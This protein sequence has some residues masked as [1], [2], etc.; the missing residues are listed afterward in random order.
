[1]REKMKEVIKYLERLRSNI[2]AI[3]KLRREHK[4]LTDI[5]EKEGL[6][7]S[8]RIKNCRVL[9]NRVSEVIVDE[10]FLKALLQAKKKQEVKEIKVVLDA[11][12]S[13]KHNH[14]CITGEQYLKQNKLYEFEL[15][16][17]SYEP[18]FGF[19]FDLYEPVFGFAF[20]LLY[21]PSWEFQ[22]AE[23]LR[24]KTSDNI[25]EMYD[26][27][28]GTHTLMINQIAQGRAKF[29]AFSMPVTAFEGSEGALMKLV[30]KTTG[31]TAKSAIQ[32]TKAS[33]VGK[34]NNKYVNIWK[35][36]MIHWNIVE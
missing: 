16:F 17:N 9:N 36:S 34:L 30:F 6:L 35:G 7:T 18:G 10:Q 28:T 19:A 22:N 14:L 26:D 23:L 15:H 12:E 8:A 5:V 27:K 32:F 20:D 3:S 1:M 33:V 31:K 4:V 21:P 2:E 24:C 11:P 29:M 13:P 25:Q